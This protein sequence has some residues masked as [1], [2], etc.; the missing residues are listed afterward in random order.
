MDDDLKY[1]HPF[2]SIISEL[3]GSAKSSF[4]I[5]FLQ[6]LELLCTEQNFDG[7]IIKCCSE[8]TAVPTEQL[9]VRAN[10]VRFNDGVSVNLE[11]KNGKPCLIIL[12]DILNNV[13]SKQVR[14][15][16]TKSSHHRNI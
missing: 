9:A 13:Y 14:N 8:R 3:T 12:D 6:N 7:G 15:L 10:N 5:R 16:F 2:T 1:K 4:C 11:N